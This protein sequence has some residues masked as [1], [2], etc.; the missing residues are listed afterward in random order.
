MNKTKSTEYIMGLLTGAVLML[1]TVMLFNNSLTIGLEYMDKIKK[2]SANC[3]GF[4]ALAKID[5]VLMLITVMLFNNSLTAGAKEI[6]EVRIINHDWEPIP[7]LVK[8]K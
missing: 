8:D 1:I 6:I 7:V 3:R 5:T 4:F 2:G